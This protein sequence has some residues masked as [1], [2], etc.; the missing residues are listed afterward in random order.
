MAQ[1]LF[2]DVVIA[3]SDETV[4]VEGNYYFPPDAIK[5]EYFSET[6]AYN[7][8]CPW[9]GV[10]SYYDVEVDGERARAVAWT[11]KDPSPAAAAIKDHI[12]FYPQV[13]IEGASRPGF[14]S[15]R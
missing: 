3:E 5:A 9:K 10:A 2:N 8:T 7:T 12:A 14:F 1:A 15:R 6:P 11:Y 4:M 13:R